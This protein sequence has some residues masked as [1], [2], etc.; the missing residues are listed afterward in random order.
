MSDTIFH[1]LAKVLDTLPNGFPSTESGVEIKLLKKIFTP[2]EADLF[3]DLRMMPATPAQISQRTGRP[4]EGLLEKL[5][6]MDSRGQLS[7]FEFGGEHYFRMVPW[8]FGIYEFQLHWMDREFAELNE[9]YYPHFIRQFSQTR[10]ALMQTLPIEEEIVV[11]QAALPYEQVSNILENS[12][13]I[14]VRDC[15]CKKEQGLI[16][17]P[18]DR[19]VEV[20]L[21]F[22]P[23]PGAFHTNENERAI[24]KEEARTIIKESEKNAL[25]HLTSNIQSGHFYI[26]NC[27]GCCCAMLTGI[28]KQGLPAWQVVN[29]RYYAAVNPDKCS[30]CGVCADER[31]Q[32]GAIEAGDEAYEIIPEKCIG[33][34]LCITTCD[35]QAIQLLEKSPD[36]ITPP[37]QDEI[38]WYIEKGRTRGV[39][40]SQYVGKQKGADYT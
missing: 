8:L 11:T 14:M 25:V 36:Q 16:D 29:S 6:E 40:F 24:S 7:T 18:C 15:I 34:G 39:D 28:T 26:C 22:A 19:P 2:E 37:P 4:L 12:E 30:L 9:E 31:C 1:K 38:A 13:S 35:E 10:P 5:R 17:N 23:V 27:C 21:V 33:C 20:C 32:V 3:C